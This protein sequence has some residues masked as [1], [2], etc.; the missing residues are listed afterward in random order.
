MIKTVL[1]LHAP[2]FVGKTVCKVNLSNAKI[3]GDQ[4]PL[5]LLI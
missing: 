1:G 2:R 3:Y 4:E 5:W